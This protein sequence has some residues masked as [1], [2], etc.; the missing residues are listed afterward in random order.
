MV[1]REGDAVEVAFAANLREAALA[2]LHEACRVFIDHV[3][4]RA[5]VDVVANAHELRESLPPDF[6]DPGIVLYPI[7]PPNPARPRPRVARRVSAV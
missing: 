7:P 2:S 1:Y 4:G 3:G 5:L 6:G